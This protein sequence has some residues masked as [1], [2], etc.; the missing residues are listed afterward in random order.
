MGARDMSYT[1]LAAMASEFENSAYR[2]VVP[3]VVAGS[4]TSG[5]LPEALY[6][7]AME[8]INAGLKVDLTNPM[9]ASENY[10]LG[11]ELLSQALEGAQ[12]GSP[13]TDEMQR[14]LDMVEERVRLITREAYGRSGS[15]SQ[16]TT[17]SPMAPMA[18]IEADDSFK[19]R[20]E[21]ETRASNYFD[22]SRPNELSSE[23][24]AAV[25]LTSSLFEQLTRQFGFQ[26]ESAHSQQEHLAM[27]LA[28]SASHAPSHVDASTAGLNALHAKLLANYRAWARHLGTTPQCAGE[29]DVAQNK[30][31]DLVLYVLV[32]GEAANLR[33][34]PESLCF[35]FH[36]MRTELWKAGG[37]VI[38]HRPQGWFLS[39]VIAPLY[40]HMR[41]EMSKK[42]DKGRPLGHT[43][44]PNYDD[45][46]EFFWS[47]E[48]LKYSY[49]I[50][51][52]D[53]EAV[54]HAAAV[55]SALPSGG[56]LRDTFGGAH[57]TPVSQLPACKRYVERRS[58]PKAK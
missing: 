32:W 56:L 36:S 50:P 2:S 44:K 9:A 22:M 45:F 31:T 52:D 41:T 29:S 28:N 19:A 35:L 15:D 14:T 6:Q 23:L 40:R 46:N 26:H 55:S 4:S 25:T 10:Q 5:L 8:L 49:H 51:D 54:A 1:N 43:R 39:R 42:D 17:D 58:W 13:T 37:T 12:P 34:V 16:S 11:A 3:A 21:P 18:Q 53:E 57:L 38:A 33:H 20:A 48:C 47:T 27:L 7:K 30:A 24:R